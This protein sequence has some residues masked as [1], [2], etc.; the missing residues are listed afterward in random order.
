MSHPFNC[1]RLPSA[2]FS[3]WV[4][5]ALFRPQRFVFV[6]IFNHEVL[7]VHKQEREAL[8]AGRLFMRENQPGP[9]HDISFPFFWLRFAFLG[10][11]AQVLW[12]YRVP[13]LPHRNR[14]CFS[15]HVFVA[16]Y[17]TREGTLQP[18]GVF[19]EKEDAE[20]A[21]LERRRHD[22]RYFHPVLTQT[23]LL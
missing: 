9:W 3:A 13:L 4:S 11:N 19:W 5:P 1:T 23:R 21:L 12:I 8:E 14:L 22:P 2:C 6:V 16:A 20:N 10:P 7:S 18:L 15:L 17:V